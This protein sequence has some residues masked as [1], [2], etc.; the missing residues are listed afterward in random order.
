MSRGLHATYISISCRLSMRWL[1]A[2]KKINRNIICIR[3][4][5]SCAQAIELQVQF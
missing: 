5:T 2:E 3:T 4:M 1:S